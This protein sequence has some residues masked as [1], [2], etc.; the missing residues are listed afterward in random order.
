MA[1]VAQQPC[2][3]SHLFS[4]SSSRLNIYRSRSASS[5]TSTQPTI[6]DGTDT[7]RQKRI[8][9]VQRVVEA[10]NAL[11]IKRQ[12]EMGASMPSLS[13][14]TST[15]SSDTL[16]TEFSDLTLADAEVRAFKYFL[17]RWDSNTTQPD[18]EFDFAIE[19]SRPEFE[20][21]AIRHFFQR[22]ASW[23][24][25]DEMQKAA[26]AKLRE[27]RWRKKKDT[28]ELGKLW[29]VERQEHSV[30][31]EL[32]EITTR[33]GLA[34]LIW[35]LMHDVQAPLAPRLLAESKSAVRRMYGIRS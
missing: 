6:F 12:G 2:P 10:H 34:Q 24:E 23:D 4:R 18:P 22:I 16:R 29:A 21:S 15:I 20:E 28:S 7:I 5:A 14:S 13:R 27:P 3:R 25:S 9:A 1:A 26:K 11:E 19:S 17:R 8:V 33:E 30:K 32:K 31:D 35:T